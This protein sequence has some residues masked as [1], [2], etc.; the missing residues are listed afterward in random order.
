MLSAHRVSAA[1]LLYEQGKSG[2]PLGI[3]RGC[4]FGMF[5]AKEG[6]LQQF[7]PRSTDAL[8]HSLDLG[9]QEGC[10]QMHFEDLKGAE[11]SKNE[12]FPR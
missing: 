9:V 7:L 2:M 6:L 8:E 10:W 4:F 5:R 11:R 12:V 3:S 1:G